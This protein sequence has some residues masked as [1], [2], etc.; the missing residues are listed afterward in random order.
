MDLN[1]QYLVG[2]AICDMSCENLLKAASCFKGVLSIGSFLSVVRSPWV[3]FK[4]MLPDAEL[5]T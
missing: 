3:L 4:H 2:S 1:Y 5:H